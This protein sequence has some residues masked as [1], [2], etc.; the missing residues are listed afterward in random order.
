MRITVCRFINR[1]II[2]CLAMT[3]LAGYANAQP[4]T[5]IAFGSCVHQDR[6]QPI[7]GQVL[8]A[9]PDVFVFLGDNIYGDSDDPAV[10]Q[11]RYDQL[12]QVD[13]FQR[14]REQAKVVAIWDDHDYG[15][16]D[17]GLEYVS[18]E[19]SRQIMLDFWEEPA[20]S[21]RRTR[22]DGIY[23]SYTFGE[24]GQ[25][26]QL[27]LLDLRWNRTSLVSVSDSAQA[28]ARTA[29]DMGP[30]EVS[31]AA[32][33]SML[34]QT[35]WAWFE[36]Q[37]QEPADLRIIGSSIQLLAD[38]TGWESWA[39]FPADR[40]RF[41]EALQSAPQVPTMIISGDTHWSEVSRIDD[42]GLPWPLV[43]VT[44]SGLTEEWYAIS[45]N[46]HRVGEAF[47]QANFGLLTIDWRGE[48]P[49]VNVQIRDV[50]GQAIINQQ[51]GF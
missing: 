6:P 14:L 16:N 26:V 13:G 34:G 51:V 22:D 5:H 11:S 30:Y 38:F 49:Q 3:C 32:G 12:G 19:A 39:N 35:Q 23:T 21:E 41:F 43:D 17:A 25:R 47:A 44:S 27:I 7:W 46:R 48:K 10:L 15:Q 4:V 45:P 50:D 29:A 28:A 33:A 20:D 24:T 8:A 42:V 36:Q 18:K 9:N 31:L 40:Q 1:L 37:L 2:S